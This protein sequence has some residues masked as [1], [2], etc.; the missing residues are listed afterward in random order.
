MGKHTGIK[1]AVIT[2]RVPEE[3]RDAIKEYS[4]SEYRTISQQVS[5]VLADFAR[6]L[7]GH[8]GRTGT[9]GPT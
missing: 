5:L 4:A 8:A 6:T 1:T 7:P 9:P 3:L 2:A